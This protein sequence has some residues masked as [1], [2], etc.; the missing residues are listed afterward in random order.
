M[1]RAIFRGSRRGFDSD[2]VLE[3]ALCLPFPTPEH[4]PMGLPRLAELLNGPGLAG[5]AFFNESERCE[6]WH[7]C[8]HILLA[9]GQSYGVRPWAAEHYGGV[10]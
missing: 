4:P 9:C 7:W 3:I 1:P 2:A 10:L 8:K 6:T 5:S